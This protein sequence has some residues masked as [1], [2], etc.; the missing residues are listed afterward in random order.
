MSAYADLLAKE[1]TVEA[2]P[3]KVKPEQL[4]EVINKIQDGEHSFR[5]KLKKA[6]PKQNAGP[7]RLRP[8]PDLDR[9][10]KTGPEIGTAIPPFE[11]SDQ[12][13]KLQTL[14]TL[15]GPKGLVL[16]FVRSADW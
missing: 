1:V 16:M 8:L 6:G 11:A 3:G 7:P 12:N 14:E 4:I 5:A 9:N 2:Q 10:V 13:G 15:R